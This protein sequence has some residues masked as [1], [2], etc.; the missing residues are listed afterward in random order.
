QRSHAAVP[1]G[2]TLSVHVLPS[3][4]SSCCRSRAP[5][6]QTLPTRFSIWLQ[7]ALQAEQVGV[8]YGHALS[9][10][11]LPSSQASPGSRMPLPQIAPGVVVVVVDEL[12]VVGVLVVVGALVVVNAAHSPAMQ[13]P[14]QHWWFAVHVAR[15]G[16]QL[17]LG[18]APARR[19]ATMTP[20]TSSRST[21]GINPTDSQRP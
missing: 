6:P 9:V 14:L 1:D 11:W 15:F 5:S 12:V 4:Q 3:S 13:A 21:T 2:H 10:C 7:P 19:G 8:P 17:L 16:L 20:I 18:P